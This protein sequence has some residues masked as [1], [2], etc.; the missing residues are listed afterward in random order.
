MTKTIKDFIET[1]RAINNLIIAIDQAIKS[2]GYI[3]LRA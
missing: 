3:L 2:G 1:A